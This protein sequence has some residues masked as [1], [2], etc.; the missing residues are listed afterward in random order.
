MVS[1][2]TLKYICTPCPIPLLNNSNVNFKTIP[3]TKMIFLM[4]QGFDPLQKN[5]L[6]VS[7][8]LLLPLFTF[9]LVVEA[10]LW[11]VLTENNSI[12]W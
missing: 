2:W 10:L 8:L 9:M 3:K 4:V 6:C 7:S 5:T 1:S 12:Y 11:S